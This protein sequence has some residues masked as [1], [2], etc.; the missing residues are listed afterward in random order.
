L[1]DSAE[2]RL[3]LINAMPRW[4]RCAALRW[5]RE[6]VLNAHLENESR[7]YA[8]RDTEIE[9]FLLDE[10]DGGFCDAGQ[11]ERFLNWRRDGGVAE[12]PSGADAASG[13]IDRM[14]LS[15]RLAVARFRERAQQSLTRLSDAADPNRLHVFLNPEHV[16]TGAS[17]PRGVASTDSSQNS[18]RVL[19]FADQQ[20]MRS[21]RLSE[22]EA[23]LV[24]RLEAG[25]PMTF[26]RFVAGLSRNGTDGVSRLRRLLL[27]GLVAVA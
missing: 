12:T 11:T 2:F 20:A 7:N 10:E 14:N 22:D 1:T 23:A 24:S 27:I 21:V 13:Q 26:K 5:R 4:A 8:A 6:V 16:W 19:L 15:R 17:E 9:R 18:D 3:M 25:G